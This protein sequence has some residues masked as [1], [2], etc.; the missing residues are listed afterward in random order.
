M[1]TPS[2]S[3]VL[4][5]QCITGARANLAQLAATHPGNGKLDSLLA[6]HSDDFFLDVCCERH[7]E[8]S[9]GMASLC[10]PEIGNGPCGGYWQCCFGKLRA[11]LHDLKGLESSLAPWMRSRLD[12]DFAIYKTVAPPALPHLNDTL[13]SELCRVW[14]PGPVGLACPQRPSPRYRGACSDRWISF[15]NTVFKAILWNAPVGAWPVE[16]FSFELQSL[17]AIP[18][19][20][21][22]PDNLGTI[23]PAPRWPEGLLRRVLEHPATDFPP[24]F[25]FTALPFVREGVVLIPSEI[26]GSD[27]LLESITTVNKQ[28]AQKP[29]SSSR[30]TLVWRGSIGDPDSIEDHIAFPYAAL[31]S[32]NSES[33]RVLTEAVRRACQ[34]EMRGKFV[35]MG[36]DFP[37]LLDCKFSCGRHRTAEGWPK[38]AE[39]LE[40]LGLLVDR[41]PLADFLNFR[42]GAIL[43]GWTFARNTVLTLALDLTPFRAETHLQWWYHEGLQPWKHYVP[44]KADVSLTDV[45]DKLR[46]ATAEPAAAWHIAQASTAFAMRWFPEEMQ[47]AYVAAA[48]IRYAGIFPTAGAF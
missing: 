5:P 13:G 30:A 46:W 43:D 6:I 18:P 33:R 12:Q 45:R 10:W 14:L 9:A 27:R 8:G 47:M 38:L 24:V 11:T 26:L 34:I 23:Y 4:K 35:A 41:M 1:G 44:L 19:K 20:A 16:G 29:W 25:C 36:M 39:L 32:N 15:L 3:L 37:E 21:G 40:S 42:F 2:Q 17:K 31:N 7:Y 28:R 22:L 48:L